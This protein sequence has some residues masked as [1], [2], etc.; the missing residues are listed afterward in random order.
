MKCNDYF[1]KLED[2]HKDFEE[3]DRFENG[4][5]E[6]CFGNFYYIRFKLSNK[7]RGYR[8]KVLTELLQQPYCITENYQRV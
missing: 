4:S 2:D 5:I 8:I 3:Q 6:I 7:V 1:K